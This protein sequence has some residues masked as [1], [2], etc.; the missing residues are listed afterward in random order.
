[1]TFLLREQFG[2]TTIRAIGDY[3]RAHG[4][5][6][7]WI[8]KDRGQLLIHVCD[9]RD[10]AFLRSRYSDLLDPLPPTPVTKIEASPVAAQ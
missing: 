7:H 2:F 10:E 3:L 4:S 1:M 5:G 8:E 9:P 6:H